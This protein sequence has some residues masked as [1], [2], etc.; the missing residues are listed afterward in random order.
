LSSCRSPRTLAW[1]CM[2]GSFLRKGC[3]F[4]R[5]ADIGGKGG[6]KLMSLA[7]PEHAAP[8]LVSCLDR[9]RVS[10]GD[11]VGKS[12]SKSSSSSTTLLDPPPQLQLQLEMRLNI[13]D[14]L[15]AMHIGD[16]AKA[17]GFL[18]TVLLWGI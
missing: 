18:P 16:A 12:R 2:G 13:A 9:A 5:S 6:S 17:A 14:T 4:S 1:K 15:L 11:I 10:L 7:E 3:G 8:L